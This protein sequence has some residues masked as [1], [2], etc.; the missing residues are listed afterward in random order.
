MGDS[1]RREL[2]RQ[3][4]ASGTLADEA[5]YLLEQ[6]RGGG[7]QRETLAF[8]AYC[9]HPAARL[10]LG[11]PE[12]PM[13]LGPWLSGLIGYGRRERVLA[14]LALARLVVGGS[15]PHESDTVTAEVLSAIEHWV[16]EPTYERAVAVYESPWPSRTRRCEGDGE[17]SQRRRRRSSATTC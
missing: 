11:E 4:K 6:V 13:A 3:W 5:A 10:A 2:E 8:A 7:L 1:K 17:E 12:V 14:A 16:R 15:P 9:A